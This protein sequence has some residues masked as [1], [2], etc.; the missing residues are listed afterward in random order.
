MLLGDH[1]VVYGE[2]CI[3]TAVGER[4]F[5]I[6]YKTSSVNTEVDAPQVKD[7]RFVDEAVR[8]FF[9]TAGKK[10]GV[11]LTTHSNFSGKYGFGSSSAVTVATF[12]ALSVLFEHPLTQRE[13]FDMSYQVVLRVQGV[14]SGFDLA[15]AVWGGSL[16]FKKGGELVKSLRS[17]S[18]TE[19]PLIVGYTGVKSNTVELVK[20]VAGLY[21]RYPAKVGRTFKAIG[22]IVRQVE[23]P[24]LNGDWYLVGQFMNQSQEHLKQL[25]VSSAK[26]EHMIALARERGAWGAKLSG[27]GGGDC[28]IALVENKN[29]DQVAAAWQT[30]GV[31]M[32]DVSVNAEGVKIES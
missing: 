27:A 24:L 14:G 31:E 26:L 1:A 20:R 22:A 9:E 23:K 4:M 5:V 32:L 6:A 7:T 19:V 13:L 17:A 12:K 2:P 3:V 11:K 18:L 21:R 25:N 16:L 15:A 29:R 28:M 10:S 30:A 8:A